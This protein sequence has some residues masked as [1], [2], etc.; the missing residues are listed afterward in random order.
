MNYLNRGV[1]VLFVVALLGCTSQN[2]GSEE[3][4][5]EVRIVPPQELYGDLFYEVQNRTDLFPDSKTFVDVIP[6]GNVDNILEEYKNLENKESSEVMIKFLRANFHIPGYEESGEIPSAAVATDHIENL[7]SYLERPADTY[8]TG[9]KIPLPNTYVVPGG[10]FREVYYWDSYFTMLGL[11]VDGRDQLIDNILANFSFLID[12]VG[13]VP[14]GNRTYYG[15]RSQPPFY[16]LMVQLSLEGNTSK[17][18]TDY[19]DYLLK[20]Y[21]FWM[22]GD[23]LLNEEMDAHRRVVQLTYGGVLNRYWDDSDTPR[24][25]SYR[26]DVETVERALEKDENRSKGEAY[27]HL[28]AAAESGWDFSSRW[29]EIGEDGEFD[30]STIHTTDI[31]PVDLNALIYNLEKVISESYALRGQDIESTIFNDKAVARKSLID[32]YCWSEKEGFYM[33]YDFVKG[34]HTPVKSLAGVFPLFFEMTDEQKAA[35]V[36]DVVKDQFLMKGGVVTTLNNSGQQWDFPNGWAPLQWMTIKSLRNYRKI[37]LAEEIKRRWLELNN[38]VFEN[39][40][41]MTEKYNVID[42]SLEGGGGEYPNQDGFGWTNGVFQKL[43]KE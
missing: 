42:M 3:Q 13:F 2:A 32:K 41:K 36:S 27:R 20:E 43:A 15:T 18:L 24:P 22:A 35:L 6:N 31:I 16:S 7:W 17:S 25:E 11:K 10:R 39:T 21:N 40:G 1:G 9:T 37:D 5:E 34:E 14:N 26:E 38:N 30:L 8:E 28:R 12:S 29:F 19:H 23:S 4:R 33:D